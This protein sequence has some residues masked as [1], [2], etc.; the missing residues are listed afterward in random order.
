M[1]FTCLKYCVPKNVS[2]KW[3]RSQLQQVL[4]DTLLDSS[5][6]SLL[7]DQV[8]NTSKSQEAPFVWNKFDNNC[9]CSELLGSREG[10]FIRWQETGLIL[11]NSIKFFLFFLL[12]LFSFFFFVHFLFIVQPSSLAVLFCIVVF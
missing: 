6:A 7:K 2:A 8:A 12:L 9:L 3:P 1:C 5:R 11:Y 4:Q 10:D